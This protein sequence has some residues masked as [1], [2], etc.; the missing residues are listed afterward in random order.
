MLQPDPGQRFDM[1]QVMHAL[2]AIAAGNTVAWDTVASPAVAGGEFSALAKSRKGASIISR[3][4][5]RTA[6]TA[7]T[8]TNVI[9]S[10]TRAKAKPPEEVRA[11]SRQGAGAAASSA[12]Q[13]W[14]DFSAF[15]ASDGPVANRRSGAGS[16][17]Q[18][19][20]SASDR[21]KMAARKARKSTNI[22]R[23]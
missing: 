4:G 23:I 3:R 18:P 17:Q 20:A 19:F 14:A 7:T 12:G 8:A 9:G 13:D 21:W 2:D 22:Y 5:E 6:T 11:E 16:A 10:G 15:G 1:Q